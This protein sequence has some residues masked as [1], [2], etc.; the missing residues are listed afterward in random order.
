M[1]VERTKRRLTHV[2]HVPRVISHVEIMRKCHMQGKFHS[3]R[4]PVWVWVG[5]WIKL[6]KFLSQTAGRIESAKRSR[7]FVR[8]ETHCSTPRALCLAVR[9]SSHRSTCG[10]PETF[11]LLLAIANRNS[12]QIFPLISHFITFDFKLKSKWF[13]HQDYRAQIRQ[14]PSI[15][16]EIKWQPWAELRAFKVGTLL[17]LTI[18][19]WTS[20]TLFL[21]QNLC[22]VLSRILWRIL[23]K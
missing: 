12:G 18:L 15:F 16:L 6:V 22:R 5:L 4:S 10:T 13:I 8:M 1:K 19:G 11:S 23:S 21:D 2:V 9:V 7:I 14:C 17:S 3:R 20:Q